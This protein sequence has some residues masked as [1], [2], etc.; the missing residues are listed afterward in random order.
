MFLKYTTILKNFLK[1]TQNQI[2]Q[3][4]NIGYFLQV[5]GFRA[6][7]LLKMKPFIAISETFCLHFVLLNLFLLIINPCIFT[8]SS[9][10]HL[11]S[12]ITDIISLNM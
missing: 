2:E 11:A 9:N 5:A 10:K 1:L 8:K 7:I 3:S 12:L 6:K 4:P